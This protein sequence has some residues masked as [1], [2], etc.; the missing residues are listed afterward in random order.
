M[1]IF[2][3]VKNITDAL[4]TA[5]IANSIDYNETVP[6]LPIVFVFPD[7]TNPITDASGRHVIKYRHTIGISCY[8]PIVNIDL[9]TA[10][11]NTLALQQS[12]LTAINGISG[13]PGYTIN[14]VLYGKVT[15]GSTPAYAIY[16]VIELYAPG[17]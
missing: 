16:T 12:V 7:K 4:A 15:L 13:F 1:D 3:L 9:P 5:G 10:E 17:S 6:Q 11:S 2:S 8:G 14:E